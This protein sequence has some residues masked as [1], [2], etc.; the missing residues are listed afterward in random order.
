MTVPEGSVPGLRAALVRFRVMAALVGVALIV[1]VFVG[2]PLQLAAGRP[3]VVHVL[4]PIHGFLYIAYLVAAADLIRRGRWPL[5]QLA[6][7][8]L[9]GLVPFLAFVVSLR[10]T[11]RAQEQL[12]AGLS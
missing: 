2:V 10:I 3:Q 9:A 4:G 7:V 5:S 8:I 6:G 12:G 11:R 1:L